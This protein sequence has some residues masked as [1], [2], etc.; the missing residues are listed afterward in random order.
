MPATVG[1]S[2]TLTGSEMG[3]A[4]AQHYTNG[5]TA[6]WGGR[7]LSLESVDASGAVYHVPDSLASP[8]E[9]VFSHV[10]LTTAGA[11][12]HLVSSNPVPIA[13]VPPQTGLCMWLERPNLSRRFPAGTPN[14]RSRPSQLC[15]RARA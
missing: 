3:W 6:T 8:S 10:A 1:G 4:H 5:V 11:M 14:L 7:K 2:I 9:L 15:E 13:C 12:H